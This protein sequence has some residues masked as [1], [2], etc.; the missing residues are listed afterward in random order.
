M[1]L[2]SRLKVRIAMSKFLP[3]NSRTFQRDPKGRLV[4]WLWVTMRSMR[5]MRSMNTQIDQ[6]ISALFKLHRIGHPHKGKPGK[7]Q[8]YSRIQNSAQC[9][10]SPS[11][12]S[13][14]TSWWPIS[15]LTVAWAAWFENVLRIVTRL[16]H[17]NLRTSEIVSHKKSGSQL[18]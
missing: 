11:L 1:F 8:G 17:L 13:L 18:S 2:S 6:L 3:V 9:N 5:S 7:H 16:W 15:I 10:G 4:D 14:S 12:S